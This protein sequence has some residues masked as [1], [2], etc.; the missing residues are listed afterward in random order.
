MLPELLRFSSSAH[1]LSLI[2]EDL[3]AAHRGRGE[4]TGGQNTHNI[5]NI[6]NIQ[7][8]QDLP[9]LTQTEELGEELGE[10]EEDCE[11]DDEVSEAEDGT[12]D[13]S[14]D[15]LSRLGL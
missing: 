11:E 6:Q 9:R 3:Q 1:L 4:P 7:T 12:G 10:S 13:V 5:Q 15:M 14:D 2:P 8:T